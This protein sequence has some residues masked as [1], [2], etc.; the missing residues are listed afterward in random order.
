MRNSGD[1]ADVSS[2]GR[3]NDPDGAVS[4]AIDDGAVDWRSAGNSASE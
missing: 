4:V 1:G 3:C 2:V